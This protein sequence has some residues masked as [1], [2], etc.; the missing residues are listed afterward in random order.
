MGSLSDMKKFVQK[1]FLSMFCGLFILL[2]WSGSALA[3]EVEAA[4]AILIDANTGRVLYEQNAHESLAPASTT[5]IL[6]ALITLEE[7]EDLSQTV[8]LPDDFV[9]VGESGIYLEPGEEHSFEDLLY[10]LMLRSANDAGQALGIGVAGSEE[11]FVELM[12]QRTQEM[13]LQD[14]HWANPH[15]LDADDHYTSAHDL[16]MITRE[17]LRIPKFNELIT[18]NEWTMP[19]LSNTDDRSLYNHNQFL[20][21][22]EGGDG[23]KTGYTSKAGNCLVASA[24]RDGL[25]LIGV[26]LNCNEQGEHY[27]EMCS[28]MDYGFTSYDTVTMGQAGD[29]VGSVRVQNGNVRRVNAVLAED[30]RI[31]LEKGQSAD[32]VTY[33]YE[34]SQSVEAPIQAGTQVGVA[35]YTDAKGTVTE[36]PICVKEGAES[37]TF[38]LVWRRVW[39]AFFSALLG[40][41]AAE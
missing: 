20:D 31:L 16:A 3:F 34:F 29:L 9:N 35:R 1:F 4:A 26:V 38:G 41:P 8:V 11:A 24:T 28:L 36:I 14:S 6:T 25:R 37:Y 13:G 5:K 32:S 33:K 40:S 12:N 15:G 19:W 23:V 10:A 7:V 22:Y 27:Q 21:I 30:A 18:A 2:A 17:A 39:Q